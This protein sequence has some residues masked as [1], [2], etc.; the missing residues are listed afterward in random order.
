[1]ICPL[2]G[3]FGIVYKGILTDWNNVP[4]QGVAM[5]TL[6]GDIIYISLSDMFCNYACMV[7]VM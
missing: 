2:T 7:T 5:K 6:K 1:M 3:E 4:I